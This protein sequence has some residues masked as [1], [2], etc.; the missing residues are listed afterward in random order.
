MFLITR[1]MICTADDKTYEVEKR[2]LLQQGLSQ[3]RIL[4]ILEDERGFMWFGSADGLNRYDGYTTKI[5]RNRVGDSIS[6][7]NNIINSMV[8]DQEGN[9]WLGTNNGVAIFNPYTEKC[10]SLAETDSTLIV[11]GANLINSCVI[12][13]FENIWC[14]TDG[15]GVIKIDGK[16]HEKQYFFRNNAYP[17]HLNTVT[18][19]FIDRNNRLWIGCF[20]ENNIPVYLIDND[21]LTFF[22]VD[23]INQAKE[24]GFNTTSFY[25]DENHRIWMSIVD[26]D[27]YNGGLFYLETGG[28]QFVNYKRLVDPGFF[29]Q[30]SD[31]LNSI[32]SIVGDPKT[33][34]IIFGSLFGGIFTFHFGE[35]PKA[36]YLKSPELD[37]KILCLLFGSNS[38]LWIG[39]NGYGVELSIPNSTFFHH[40]SSKTN[41]GFTVESI[42]AFT[43]DTNYYWVGGYY[44]LAKMDKHFNLI[45]TVYNSSVY[46]IA[47]N[48][49]DEN[50]LWIGSEGGGVQFINKKSHSWSQSLY[51]EGQN[52]KPSVKYIQKIFPVSDTLLLIG[53]IGGLYGVNPATHIT[54][55]Y[56]YRS[57]SISS[58]YLKV[59]SIS[60]V[61]NGK[62]LIGYAD[63]EIG[64]LDLVNSQVVKFELMPKIQNYINYNPV[65]CVYQ[66][67]Q[68]DYWIATTNGL[69]E[70]NETG[71][72]VRFFTEEDGLPNSHIYGILPDEDDKLWLSTN[73]GISC[74]DPKENIFRN[75]DVS[76]GLQNN[77]FNTGAYYKAKNGDLF[78]GGINGFNYFNPEEIKQNSIVPQIEITGIKIANNTLKLTKEQWAEHH[79]TIQPDEEVFAIEFAGLS[80][81]N[82]DKNQYKYRIREI[83]ED[84]VNL[85]NQHQIAFNNM[86]PG[87]YTLEILAANN[88]GIW[89]EQPYIFNINVLPTFFESTLFV[90]LLVIFIVLSVFIAIRLRLRQLK[91]QK[92]KLQIYADEQ[93]ANLRT[94]NETLREEI[95]K[96]ENTTKKLSASNET[97]D[98]FLS[99]IG[100]DLIGPLGVIQGFSELL[101]EDGNF[102]AEEKKSFAQT[103]NLTGKELSSLLINLLQWSKLKSD[104]IP[105]N[106]SLIELK[107]NINQSVILLQGNLNEKKISLQVDIME[108]TK[109]FVDKN[110]LST[111]LRNLLS[112]AIK[113]TPKNG[114]ITI[115]SNTVGFMEQISVIDTGVGISKE[116]QAKIFNASENFTTKGTNN[117]S[118]TGLGLGLVHEFVLLS[119]GEISVDSHPGK[120][121]T[122]IFS[123]PIS[124][125]NK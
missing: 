79:L 116:N 56:P 16:T 113:F 94:A 75:Y 23:R 50:L 114:R 35:T 63:G 88:H 1:I 87:K 27:G 41:T 37:P 34:K 24:K 119:K 53:T 115:K 84:W 108:D 59:Q 123:L 32:I 22:E 110:M 111:I 112:N 124:N 90:V 51:F 55:Y 38:I 11:L 83:N 68:N 6:I 25:E 8:E 85:E 73:N 66:N 122:F 49:L 70:V 80:Y 10:I 46:S 78:F 109:V 40:I 19:L 64:Q 57:S 17:Q 86:S 106:P 67:D 9:I 3:S 103:I 100:H 54:T 15:Y 91:L 82:S 98:K 118:G 101:I 105:L 97:K 4:S 18:N 81:V 93:T 121:T 58:A 104:T 36:S 96:H 45:E 107:D 33:D 99:I 14:G 77:E 42:R 21:S 26:Y 44:G 5:F 47:N 28:E 30:M 31:N 102:S 13:H 48:N 69:L 76:D 60:K 29:D 95:L 43:E 74:Y 65:N 72:Q 71:S 120:G 20:L 2:I 92:K 125:P 62:I 117:E 39:T 52:H 61:N 7:P 89:L 12:D